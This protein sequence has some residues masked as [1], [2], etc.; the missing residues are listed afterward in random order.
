MT[1]GRFLRNNFLILFLYVLLVGISLF[2]ILNYE[3]TALH[4]F[5][6]KMV[7]NK[8]LNFFFYYMTYLGDGRL[9]PLLLLIIL[10]YNIRLGICATGS[11]VCA[12]ILA[13]TLKYTFFDDDNR[14]F[15]IFSYIEPYPLKLVEGVDVHIHNSFP[16]G[17]ATQVFAI[18]MCLAFTAKNQA[19]KMLFFLIAVL[20]S[21]S[22]VY[23]SQHWQ[24][25]ITAGSAIGVVF[26]ITWFYFLVHKNRLSRFNRPLPPPRNP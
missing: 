7:G 16:S 13:I 2:F 25:D 3:K 14:P 26:S 18:F 20:T 11:L 10:L 21:L 12:T 17:H 19:L 4:I 15:Y 8:I 9:A 6:N 23:L 5:V 22:R 1:V 24:V